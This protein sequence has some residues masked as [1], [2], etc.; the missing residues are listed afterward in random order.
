MEYAGFRKSSPYLDFEHEFTTTEDLRWQHSRTEE[1]RLA[2][3]KKRIEARDAWKAQGN[4]VPP[5]IKFSTQ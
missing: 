3:L 1:N 2:C 5:E 4:T